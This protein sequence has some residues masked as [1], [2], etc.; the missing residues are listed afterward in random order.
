MTSY[1]EELNV[2]DEESTWMFWSFVVILKIITQ[3]T[4][5]IEE[6]KSEAKR[7]RL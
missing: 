5:K 6:K 4:M 1:A 2:G 3:H 7:T